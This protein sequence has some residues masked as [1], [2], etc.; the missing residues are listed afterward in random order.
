MI[1]LSTKWTKIP[2][3]EYNQLFYLYKQIDSAITFI[4]SENNEYIAKKWLVL[5]MI[6]SSRLIYM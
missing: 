4:A 6:S 2:C 3:E 1:V 5:R